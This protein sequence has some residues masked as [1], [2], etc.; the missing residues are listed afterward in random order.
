MHSIEAIRALTKRVLSSPG[1]KFSVQGFGMMRTYL[2]EDKEWRL[3]I[4]HSSLRVPNVSTIHDHPWHFD[5]WVVSGKFYNNRFVVFDRPGHHPQVT[6]QEMDYM[7]IRTGEGGG[8][9]GEI[10]T[11]YLSRQ[12]TEFYKAGDRYKQ[13]ASEVH[14]TRYEDGAVT[15]NYRR[16]V[17]TGEHARVFWPHGQ[18]WVDAEP[19]PATPQEV[20]GVLASVRESWGI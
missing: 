18:G 7:T 10:K 11:C 5:S 6:D 2:D 4:W 15:L 17:G 8:P 13:E 20:Q 12:P 14:E 19:R 3:N 9:T 1:T 16:R